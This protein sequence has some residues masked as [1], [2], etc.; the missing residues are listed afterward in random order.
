MQHTY[1]FWLFKDT[2]KAPLSSSEKSTLLTSTGLA[3]R[4]Y[5][6]SYSAFSFIFSFILVNIVSFFFYIVRQNHA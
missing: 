2:D 5:F 4:L 3:Y 1:I 6:L